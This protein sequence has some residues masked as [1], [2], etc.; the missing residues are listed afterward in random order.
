MAITASLNTVSCVSGAINTNMGSC[1]FD[2]KNFVGG[3][4]CPAGYVIPATAFASP[5]AL[6]TQLINDMQND[7][8]ALRIYPLNNFFNFKDSSEKA[9]EQ[10]FDYGQVQTVRDGIY[11]WSFEFRLGGLNLSNALRAYN[12]YAWSFLFVDSKNQLVGT[13]AVDLTGA[14]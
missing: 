6:K 3:F 4:L 14:N 13:Q 11:D 9:V 12:G 10:K 5:S 7:N 2:P 1:T 8:K